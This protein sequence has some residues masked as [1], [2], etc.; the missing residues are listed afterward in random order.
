M[1]GARLL[2]LLTEIR[3]QQKQQLAN[4]E[5]AVVNHEAALAQ[6]RRMKGYII[7]A[8]LLPWLL[9]ASLAGVL[10]IERLASK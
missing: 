1:Q 10:L 8:F 9:A 2:D 4:F 7:A 6:Q 3:D 5:R